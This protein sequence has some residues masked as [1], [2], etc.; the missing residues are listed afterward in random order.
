MNTQKNKDEA[1]SYLETIQKGILHC[2]QYYPCV[3]KVV[4]H[5]SVYN[6]LFYGVYNKI[7]GV[8]I[9][10]DNRVSQDYIYVYPK[11]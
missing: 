6:V 3:E 10:V 7:F 4:M 8:D 9:E 5:P 2:E 11:L 1:E